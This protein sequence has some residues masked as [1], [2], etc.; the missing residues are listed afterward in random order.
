MLPQEIHAARSPYE[1]PQGF[2]RFALDAMNPNI[3][4]LQ[5]KYKRE[6]EKILGTKLR[7]IYPPTNAPTPQLS[8]AFA[9]H[10]Q[11]ENPR[12]SGVFTSIQNALGKRTGLRNRCSIQR[13]RS[14]ITQLS[15]DN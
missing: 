2:G 5:D 6:V 14:R 15:S 11:K 4:E 13:S 1:W 10:R 12:R 8:N 9:K 3:G 7:V